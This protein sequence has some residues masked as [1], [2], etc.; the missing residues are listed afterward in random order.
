M[1][2]FT[3][4]GFWSNWKIENEYLFRNIKM[5]GDINY[6]IKN[7]ADSSITIDK[8]LNR[9]YLNLSYKKGKYEPQNKEYELGA[10]D[11]GVKTFAT[12]YRSNGITEIGKN[13]NKKIYKMCKEIDIMQSIRDSKGK[14]KYDK[15]HNKILYNNYQR[16]R[17]VKKAQRRKIEK[18]KRMLD[19]MHK[20]IIKYI[21]SNYERIIL[22]PFK[23][24]EMV[25]K[26]SS[27]TARQMYSMKYYD[28]RTK[29]KNK[30]EETGLKVYELSEA[31]TSRTCGNCGKIKNDLKGS[32]RTYNCNNCNLK[33][34]RDMNGARNILL[35]NINKIK[36]W[37]IAHPYL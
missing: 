1:I 37:E 25:G 6:Y 3:S 26:L 11:L 24:Q 16:R 32:D 30:A 5:S 13:A 2:L 35:K 7:V 12:I 9:T 21:T 29:I 17:N 22:P 14:Y 34:D 4:N 19:E 10:I 28:F 27:K 15:K 8:Y 20:K 33:I 31:F 23:I 18:I 36:E